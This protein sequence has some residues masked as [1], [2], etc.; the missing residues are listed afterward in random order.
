M[1]HHSA[2]NHGVKAFAGGAGGLHDFMTTREVA[3]YLRIKE[4]RVYELVR[5]EAIPCTRVTGKWLF[6]RELIDGWLAESA[7]GETPAGQGAPPVIVGS[8][9]PLLDWAVRESSCG[10]ALLPGGSLD[11]LA[12]FAEGEAQIAAL[13]LYDPESDSFNVAAAE[14]ALPQAGLVMFEWAWRNQGIVVAAGNPLGISGLADL[15]QGPRVMPRQE[16][17]GSWRLF[18]HLL[19]DA[20]LSTDDLSFT[21]ET[22]RSET[23]LGLAILE[24]RADAGFAVEA[25][26]RTLKL[27]FLPLMRERYDLLLRRRDYF[28]APVQMLLDFARSESFRR[29]AEQMGGYDIAGLGKVVSNGP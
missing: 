29:R 11:G 28:E 6:P 16:E 1:R 2:Y 5:Q 7:R 13:H 26:A 22:A 9:D 8:H 3:D 25:V 23:D 18:A 10:L 12:R 27:D 24:G 21:S 20:G 14:G 4:R 15:V 19:E 17:A